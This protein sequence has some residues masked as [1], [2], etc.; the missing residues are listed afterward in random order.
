[1]NNKTV[2]RLSE[3]LLAIMLSGVVLLFL[4]GVAVAVKATYIEL[5]VK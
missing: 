5:F 3:T 2:D 1:M 4:C